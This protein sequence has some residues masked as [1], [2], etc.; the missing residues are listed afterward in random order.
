MRDRTNPQYRPTPS[1]NPLMIGAFS[2]VR[3]TVCYK[4]LWPGGVGA[5]G[6]DKRVVGGGGW[7]EKVFPGGGGQP[8]RISPHLCPPVP[9][10]VRW[11][12]AHFRAAGSSPLRFIHWVLA[13]YLNPGLGPS[14]PYGLINLPEKAHGSSSVVPMV[15]PRTPIGKGSP[16]VW[17]L[18]TDC[19]VGT[20]NH[21]NV[22]NPRDG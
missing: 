3:R 2:L 13:R 15:W 8:C 16:G 22:Q 21:L 11:A 19:G 12:S 17:K 18:S 5:G 4:P 7:L 6:W 20:R 10:L 9:E 1:L 14:F